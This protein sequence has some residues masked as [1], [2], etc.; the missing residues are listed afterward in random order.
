M[1]N[2]ELAVPIYLERHLRKIKRQTGISMSELY[3]LAYRSMPALGIFTEDAGEYKKFDFI[4]L[5]VIIGDK[6]Y[7][8]RN[9]ITGL[10]Y[11]TGE[12]AIAWLCEQKGLDIE[13]ISRIDISG[14]VYR[15]CDKDQWFDICSYYADVERQNVRLTHLV[16]A[17]V[18]EIILLNETS[19]LWESVQ[20]LE[21]GY[22]MGRNRR[23]NHGRIVRSLNDIG[24]SL[25]D[26]WIDGLGELIID[27]TEEEKEE[28]R[29]KTEERKLLYYISYYMKQGME[30][31]DAFSRAVKR[32]RGDP[33]TRVCTI[34]GMGIRLPHSIR[35]KVI[36]NFLKNH[37]QTFIR[38]EKEQ[39]L[40][41][42][43]QAGENLESLFEDSDYELDDGP[44]Y[45]LNHWAVAVANVIMRETGLRLGVEIAQ[46]DDEKNRSCI[47]FPDRKPWLFNEK[48]KRLSYN[49]LYQILDRYALELHMAVSDDAYFITEA[50]DS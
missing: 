41:D 32:V 5:D 35:D 46:Q 17:H 34:E 14:G 11:L 12:K 2:L 19:K 16:Q 9:D 13:P 20:L 8:G 7:T 23:W 37:K 18:P 48:E 38:S 45:A 29:L 42:K 49:M 22:L 6:E 10:P 3:Q 24:F 30:S 27:E 47:V 36:P 50:E 31:G 1:L 21:S 25:V 39:E 26:G 4:E 44:Y 15:E 33:K 40:Y 28:R 43:I